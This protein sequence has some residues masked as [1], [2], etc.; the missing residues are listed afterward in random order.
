MAV[1]VAVE[2]IDRHTGA[3]VDPGI[4]HLRGDVADHPAERT[5]SGA[6]PRSAM[7]T[8]RSR[9]RHTEAISDPRNP[10]RR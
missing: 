4:A 5:S 8:V 6:L 2:A 7:V 3:Q 9:S 10:S 1:S